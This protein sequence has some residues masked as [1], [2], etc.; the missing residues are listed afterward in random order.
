MGKQVINKK[1][2]K[3]SIVNESMINSF[4]DREQ[5]SFQVSSSLIGNK[6]RLRF[7]FFYNINSITVKTCITEALAGSCLNYMDQYITK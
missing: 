7:V 2:S 4:V 1:P 6:P 5:A 3:N